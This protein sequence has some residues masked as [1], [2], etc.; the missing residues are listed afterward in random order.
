MQGV[1]H[2]SV[3]ICEWRH[4]DASRMTPDASSVPSH[5][6]RYPLNRRCLMA[7]QLHICS[8]VY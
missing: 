6:F 8:K 5:D 1:P 4:P 2:I 3:P 7:K